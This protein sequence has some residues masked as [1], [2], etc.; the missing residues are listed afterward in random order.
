MKLKKTFFI[1]YKEHSLL[2]FVTD[3]R[4][5][6]QKRKYFFLNILSIDLILF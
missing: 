6:L 2:E 1:I 5:D 4:V 3:M